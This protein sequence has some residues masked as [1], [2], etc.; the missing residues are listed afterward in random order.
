MSKETITLVPAGGTPLVLDGDILVVQADWGDHEVEVQLAQGPGIDGAIA[1]ARNRVVREVE[2]QLV[3]DASSESFVSAQ[4]ALERAVA[5][6]ADRGGAIVRQRTLE[7]GEVLGPV[8]AEVLTAALSAP[9]DFLLQRTLPLTCQPLWL[10]REEV[11][12]PPHHRGARS[13]VPRPARLPRRHAAKRGCR[14]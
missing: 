3:V 5:L 1:G 13:S 6:L 8:E 12:T 10:G 9:D 7:S 4:A 11:M 2:L 14:S